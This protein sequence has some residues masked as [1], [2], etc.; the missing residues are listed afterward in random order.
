M[1]TAVT[2]CPQLATSSKEVNMEYK[3]VADVRERNRRER[4]EEQVA[5]QAAQLEYVAMMADVEVPEVTD[6]ED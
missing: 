5:K 2:E 1:P 6:A 3:K 4:L